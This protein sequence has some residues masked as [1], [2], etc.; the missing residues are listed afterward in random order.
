LLT[1][2]EAG[3]RAGALDALVD[4]AL[5]AGAPA[6]IRRAVVGMLDGLPEAVR[7]AVAGLPDTGIESVPDSARD[8]VKSVWTAALDGELP[9]HAAALREAFTGQADAA[10]L[11]V[12]QKL[13]DALKTRETTDPEQGPDWAALRGTVHHALAMRGSRVALYDLRESFAAAT[14]PLP[15]SFL[16]AVHEV[17][18]A[19]C[20]EPLARA[21]AQAAA[22]EEWWRGQLAAAFRAIV[23]REKLTRRSAV[24]KGVEKRWPGVARG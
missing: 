14:T 11:T 2:P 6:D 17:G 5:D 20:L 8:P 3:V 23:Q 9:E 24:I 12:L 7:A 18:D 1:A 19:S 22:S 13:V 16:S 15:V 10:S 21:Y 4:M